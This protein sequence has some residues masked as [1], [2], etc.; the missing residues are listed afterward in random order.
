MM[1]KKM[2]LN[3]LVPKVSWLIAV[4]SFS[5][6][7]SGLGM[8]AESEV[9]KIDKVLGTV[10]LQHSWEPEPS[11]AKINDNIFPK[12]RIKT[13][14]KS[15]ASL[16][17][18]NGAVLDIGENTDLE[19]KEL[20]YQ[21]SDGLSKSTFKMKL[22][23][24]RAFVSKFINPESRFEIQTTTAVTGVVGTEQLVINEKTE[25]EG[26][27]KETTRAVCTVGRV[28]V[29]SIDP[30][31]TGTVTLDAFQQVWV[32]EDEPPEEV[33]DVTMEQLEQLLQDV[34]ISFEEEK[35]GE[36]MPLVKEK[37]AK[38]EITKPE[39]KPEDKIEEGKKEI[40][41][42]E[43]VKPEPEGLDLM[44]ETPEAPEFMP[45]IA[46]EPEMDILP[47]M[48]L[49]PFDG[50]DDPLDPDTFPIPEIPEPA[51]EGPLED[52]LPEPPGPP[53]N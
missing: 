37:R 47:E 18:I 21:P 52:F 23:R 6:L 38:E 35:R 1:N 12:D 43:E 2:F 3:I 25:K 30:K 36:A 7:F 5:L 46:P 17:F 41:E 8:A 24:I 29:G 22:G 14:A 53:L 16:S 48:D 50:L 49:D 40:P 31:I 26:K 45:S 20:Y 11:L 10:Y 33:M 42:K 51:D 13:N 28:K 15:K 32:Y 27:A 34:M 4:I 39:E 19:I 9:G 44:K